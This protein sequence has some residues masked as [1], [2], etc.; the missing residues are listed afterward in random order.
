M[1][2]RRPRRK[3]GLTKEERMKILVAVASKH[4]AT[5]EIAET[6]GRWLRDRDLDVDVRK[7]DDVADVDSYE[8]VV[9][10]SA[11]YMG[12]WL[13]PARKFV[14]Q[15][16]DELADRPTWLFSSGPLGTPP[17]PEWDKAVQIEAIIAM[18]GAREHRIFVGKLD[19]SR[20]TVGMRAVVRAVHAPYGDFRD[21]PAI[22]DWADE[23][24]DTLQAAALTRARTHDCMALR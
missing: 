7:V 21:W 9:L 4:G 24:A 19:K 22:A 17:K 15:H 1:P 16:A 8:A 5:E 6:I 12:K 20:L 11:V 23:I 10:G 18:T 2:P 13:E 3:L 14:E